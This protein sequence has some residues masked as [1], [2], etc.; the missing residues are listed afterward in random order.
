MEK[1]S[2]YAVI[3]TS[4]KS[5][6]DSGYEEMARLMVNLAQQQKGFISVESARGAD[7][8]GITISYWESLEDVT[9]WKNNTEHLKA[10]QLGQTKW[11]DSYKVRICKVE[12]EYAMD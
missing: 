2:Y 9:A 8:V 12:R 11:Y 1:K 4:K 5:N 6:E 3:F 7:G 10:Q